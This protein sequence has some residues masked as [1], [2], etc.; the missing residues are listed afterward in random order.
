LRAGDPTLN[1]AELLARARECFYAVEG[2]L[3]HGDPDAAAAY[4][5]RSFHAALQ[6]GIAEMRAQHRH[7]VLAF[8]DI[9][10][11]QVV[12]AQHDAS[13]DRMVAHVDVTGEDCVVDAD[14]G[15]VIAGSDAQR[16]WSEDWTLL[17]A[18]PNQ[19]WLVDGVSAAG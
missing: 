8:I 7:R 3:G 6:A 19:P 4:I 18:Q 12:A 10:G 2:G 9:A 16:H 11:V 14:S 17:R 5:T 15:A 13:G 1:E